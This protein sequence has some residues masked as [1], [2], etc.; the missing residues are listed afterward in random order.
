MTDVATVSYPSS[1]GCVY[2]SSSSSLSSL[3]LL[4]LL[5]EEQDS[6]N[7]IPRC[8]GF[9][10]SLIFEQSIHCQA[11][12]LFYL[13]LGSSKLRGG[14]TLSVHRHSFKCH[15]CSILCILVVAGDAVVTAVYRGWCPVLLNDGTIEEL[16]GD[17]FVPP[18]S[19]SIPRTACRALSPQQQCWVCS[20]PACSPGLHCPSST[21]HSADTGYYQ[22]TLILSRSTG[23]PSLTHLGSLESPVIVSFCAQNVF[24]VCLR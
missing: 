19:P 23:M 13:V 17:H 3:F 24:G 15:C 11:Y 10:Y 5:V 1:R 20:W 16:E 22:S 18:A 12:L 2:S 7:N 9:P 6:F 4:L 8:L 14:H 21:S